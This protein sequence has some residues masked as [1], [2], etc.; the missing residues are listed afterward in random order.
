MS[1]PHGSQ[2]PQVFEGAP[3][4]SDSFMVSFNIEA[5]NNGIFPYAGAVVTLANDAD[6]T[7]VIGLT[8]AE[9]I[10]GVCEESGILQG[11]INVII[12]GVITVTSDGTTAITAGDFLDVSATVDGNVLSVTT[13]PTR[14]VALTTVAQT[15]GL[16]VLALLF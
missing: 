15:A 9:F 7:C 16:P 14:M 5:D 3:F 12:R 8:H 6:E 10:L 11:Q 2:L 1:Y 13:T 4:H